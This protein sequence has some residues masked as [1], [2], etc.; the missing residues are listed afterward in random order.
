MASGVKEAF[1]H[2]TNQSQ[3]QRGFGDFYGFM[4]VA[5]GSGEMMIEYGV[6]PWDVAALVPIL[7]EAGGTFT[8]WD[9]NRTIYRP[10]ILASNGVMHTATLELLRTKRTADFQPDDVKHRELIT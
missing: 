6:S 10:D 8:D 4:L 2:I 7:E 9:G 5:Q 1:L 3:R